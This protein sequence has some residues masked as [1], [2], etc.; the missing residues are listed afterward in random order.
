MKHQYLFEIES[1]MDLAN[2]IAMAVNMGSHRV[3]FTRVTTEDE[4]RTRYGGERR[5]A[6]EDILPKIMEEIRVALE[7]EPDLVL[8]SLDDCQGFHIS[9]LMQMAVREWHFLGEYGPDL[10]AIKR[11]FDNGQLD[12]LIQ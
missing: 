10:D 12:F 4:D 6:T 9:K 8:K 11:S 7:D 1:E 3:K 5:Y 2:L